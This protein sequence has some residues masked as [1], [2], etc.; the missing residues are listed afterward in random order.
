MTS[1]RSKTLLRCLALLGLTACSN[2]LND[3]PDGALVDAIADG[4]G[5]ADAPIGP[6]PDASGDAPPAAPVPPS[7]AAQ[8]AGGG[9]ATSSGHR[10]QVRIGAPQP[11]GTATSAN[12]RTTTGPGAIPWMAP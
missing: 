5:A 8:T 2:N 4:R 7:G 6:P 1:S 11:I 9:V 3:A 10:L 12:H